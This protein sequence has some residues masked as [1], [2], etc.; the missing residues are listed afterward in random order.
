MAQAFVAAPFFVRALAN[1]LQSVEPSLLEAAKL[2]GASNWRTATSLLLPISLP[3]FVG[4]AVLAWARALGEFGATILF[5]G[6]MP[7]V[8]QTMPLAIYMGFEI[9]LDQAK[10]L[11]VILMLVAVLVLVLSRLVFRRQMTFAH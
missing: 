6:N 1:G 7:G 3:F 8:T 10:S 5:A 9:D 4:G 11:A 2:D